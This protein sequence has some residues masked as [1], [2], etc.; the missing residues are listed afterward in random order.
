[1]LLFQCNRRFRVSVMRSQVSFLRAAAII[2]VSIRSK[3]IL[4]PVS[5]YIRTRITYFS[6]ILRSLWSMLLH[7]TTKAEALKHSPNLH[8][9]NKAFP[10]R[11]PLR[12]LNSTSKTRQAAKTM[13]T[14]KT[15]TLRWTRSSWVRLK[16]TSN[17]SSLLKL[18]SIRKL[19]L[20][21]T[22]SPFRKKQLQRRRT[23]PM[24][25]SLHSS[26]LRL[27]KSLSRRLSKWLSQRRGCS[28][29]REVRKANSSLHLAVG[30]V[31][32][33][34]QQQALH[35]KSNLSRLFRFN[36]NHKTQQLNRNRVKLNQS[37]RWW[38]VVSKSEIPLRETKEEPP[39]NSAQ[40]LP[41]FNRQIVLLNRVFS[42]AQRLKSSHRRKLIVKKPLLLNRSLVKS[43]SL[44]TSRILWQPLKRTPQLLLWLL[45]E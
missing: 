33:S 10:N 2:R 38:M 14:G 20:L 15:L 32:L 6:S 34:C 37:H 19:L 26:P 18:I 9:R 30:R 4:L 44:R 24:C 1:M 8:S 31:L 45:R 13:R 21:Q 17:S 40:L 35:N 25:S 27:C 12:K 3:R 29:Q 7:L 16:A 36:L 5:K 41:S 42:L 22:S 28:R 23:L 11:A 39:R 43:R